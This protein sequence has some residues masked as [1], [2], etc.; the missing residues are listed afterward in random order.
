MFLCFDSVVSPMKL[1]LWLRHFVVIISIRL[2]PDDT[3]HMVT[4]A[5]ASSQRALTG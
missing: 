2:V 4:R 1:F 3:V 5:G